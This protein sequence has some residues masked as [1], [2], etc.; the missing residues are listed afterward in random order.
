MRLSS[1]LNQVMDIVLVRTSNPLY[2]AHDVAGWND[3]EV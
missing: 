1:Q 2:E 3:A